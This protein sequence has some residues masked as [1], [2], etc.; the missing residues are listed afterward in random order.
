M[1]TP[2]GSLV[3][4]KYNAASLL[5]R[6]DAR[7][8]GAGAVTTFVDRLDYN[9][10]GQ[11]TLVGYGNGTQSRYAYDP[12]TF[13]LVHLTTLRGSRRL[14][15]LR[16]AYDPIGNP[17]SVDDHAQQRV[18]FRN[19][20]AEP[21]SRYGYDA[22]YRLI[23]ADGRE[24]LG[25]DAGQARRAAPPTAADTLRTALPQPGDGAA[26][27]RYT[28]RYRYDQVGNLLRVT[29]R[30]ADPA[31]G[32]W[33]RDYR[34]QEPSLLEPE[35]HSNRLSGTGPARDP[36]ERYRFRYDE[37]GNTTSMPDIPA[38]RWNP[39]DRLQATSRRAPSDG[40]LA[41]PTYYI[42]DTAGQ[43]IR[44][45][46]SRTRGAGP[47]ARTAER[48]YLGTFEIYREYAADGTLAA[49]RETLHVLDDKR[50]VAL[51]E[52]R[53]AG[54]DAGPD[55]LI[56]YQLTDHL[57]SSV[58]E[59]DQAAQVITYEEYYPYGATSYQAVRARTETPKRYRYTGKER[60][61]ETG[62]YY[63]G[64]RYYAPWLGR[65]TSCDPAGL[66]DGP[67]GYVYVRDNPVSYRD[68]D[69]REARLVIDP[70]TH[71]ATVQSTVHIYGVNSAN[72]RAIQAV[73][74]Q[75]E[76][77]WASPIVAT[78]ADVEAAQKAG[79]PIP[80]RGTSATIGGQQ[81]TLKF[82]IHYQ[83]HAGVQ[84]PVAVSAPV[85]G[86]QTTAYDVNPQRAAADKFAVGDN[87]LSIRAGTGG[88]IGGMVHKLSIG[89]F[90]T[91]MTGY[92]Q[93]QWRTSSDQAALARRLVHETGHAIG[94]DERYDPVTASFATGGYPGF[95]FD[96][97][98]S[99]TGYPTRVLDPVHVTEY[100]TFAAALLAKAAPQATTAQTFLTSGYMDD[101]QGGTLLPTSR[102]Y[103][104][105]QATARK[106]A[107]A[108][109]TSNTAAWQQAQAHPAG[110]GT[111]VTP[112][113]PSGFVQ[114][115]QPARPA[116][117]P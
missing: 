26:M 35:L 83:I 13:R 45:V 56:R 90:Q 23:E 37:Q 6:L 53:T 88:T 67:S 87:A 63:H 82:D 44:K 8:R 109:A 30:P 7:L 72:L 106:D 14:Q 92:V 86:Q 70:G 96:F 27:A 69:G 15:D 71:T 105:A 18:F 55:R 9:A 49:Q 68:P 24:H 91:N 17:T 74:K 102:N 28:E 110:T 59:I 61:T 99:D 57:D 95:D 108:R 77:A 43:R 5:D 11:R 46:A 66:A 115:I 2:D 39:E 112:H 101:T 22:L 4:P 19:R 54:T 79:T 78:Q 29:H 85:G 113:V 10:R 16:Y 107:I 75:A 65:W 89:S 116:R 40:S 51:V 97:M 47:A 21:S 114:T 103:P 25:Q 111:D 1:T 12:L 104:G 84:P 48:I 50:R 94:M 117:H 73:T 34:Y 3:L 76:A 98:G 64:A 33:T 32:G 81:W 80:S 100:L 36:R 42:Y 60:D 93:G 31:A 20:V 41:D 62:L 52:E 38:L 58:L